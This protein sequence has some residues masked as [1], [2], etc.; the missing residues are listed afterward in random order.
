MTIAAMTAMTPTTFCDCT[1]E[2]GGLTPLFYLLADCSVLCVEWKKNAS[3]PLPAQEPLYL[4]PLW[5]AAARRRFS[6]CWRAR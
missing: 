3:G 2:C 1:L 6:L 5:S 4:C